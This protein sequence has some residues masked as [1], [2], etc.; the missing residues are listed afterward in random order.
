M[1][2]IIKNPFLELRLR[3]TGFAPAVTFLI[4]SALI[5]RS[6][7]VAV[8]VPSPVLSG[9]EALQSPSIRSAAI[10]SPSLTKRKRR[11]DTAP[12]ISLLTRCPLPGSKP[13][14]PTSRAAS[15]VAPKENESEIGLNSPLTSPR[16][17]PICE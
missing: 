11:F 10:N 15:M 2:A 1:R 9:R 6:R 7:I 14:Q 4:P 5:A 3:T 17:P 13:G 16:H 12:S 8:V